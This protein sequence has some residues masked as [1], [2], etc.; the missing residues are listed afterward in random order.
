VRGVVGDPE[1]VVAHAVLVGGRHRRDRARVERG[2]E[3]RARQQEDQLEV[4]LHRG[5]EREPVRLR[6]RQRALVREDHAVLVLAQPHEP[7]ERVADVR[8]AALGERLAVR[9]QR[10]AALLLEDARREPV[11]QRRRGAA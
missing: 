8:R 11:L 1:R 2:G 9:P 7:D 5:E 3:R 10:R 4:R 6:L